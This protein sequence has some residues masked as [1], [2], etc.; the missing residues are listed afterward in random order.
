MEG[1][2]KN[3]YP[4]APQPPAPSYYQPSAA[5]PPQVAFGQPQ[6][7]V[8]YG[9]PLPQMAYNQP[10]TSAGYAPVQQ[11]VALNV[12]GSGA[13]TMNPSNNCVICTLSLHF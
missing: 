7:Q 13:T 5:Q 6:P 12:V 4:M 8:G 10:H 11:A 9:Q 1:E 3:M 2:T